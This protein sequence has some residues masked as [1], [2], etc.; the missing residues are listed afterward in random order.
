VPCKI[1]PEMGQLSIHPPAC[2]GLEVRLV[3][4]EAGAV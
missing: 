3:H 4:C 2:H 1:K